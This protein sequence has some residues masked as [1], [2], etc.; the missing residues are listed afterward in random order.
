MSS[1]LSGSGLSGSGLSGSQP[2][3]QHTSTGLAAPSSDLTGAG[4]GSGLS[5]SQPQYHTTQPTSSGLSGYSQPTSNL[6]GDST[7]LSGTHGH[8][9]DSTGL[10]G[11]HGHHHGHGTHDMHSTGLTNT[12]GM[13]GTSMT[14]PVGTG[15]SDSRLAG[16]Q[17]PL[18]DSRLAGTQQP[19]STGYSDS[20][21][22]GTQQPLSTQQPLA[23]GY[24]TQPG[25]YGPAATTTQPL[26]MTGTTTGLPVN[27]GRIKVLEDHHRDAEVQLKKEEAEHKKEELKHKKE[28]IKHSKEQDKHFKQQQY[29]QEQIDKH[30][31]KL[32]EEQLQA[33]QAAAEMG[34]EGQLRAQEHGMKENAALARDEHRVVKEDAA[35]NGGSG[36]GFVSKIK[37]AAHKA[38]VKLTGKDK[39]TAL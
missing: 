11:T 19:L 34:A 12:H 13:A 5:G 39:D 9:H 28:E 16:T 33:Q 2:H 25:G 14:Q 22:A 29:H 30:T 15:Y 27:D 23:T 26:G 6:S 8:H 36:G 38:K 3:T 20:R 4:L 21:L 31:A 37:D 35:E 1:G 10:S 24:S 32:E 7:G 18:S 17:Q